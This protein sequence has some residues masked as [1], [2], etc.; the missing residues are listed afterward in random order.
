M[1]DAGLPLTRRFRAAAPHYLAGRAAYAA[2][3]IHLVARL[4]G[5]RGR[6]R[7][8]DLGCGPGALLSPIAHGAVLT[9]IV[10]TNALLAWRAG[11]QS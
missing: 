8:L 7:I 5:L 9:E 1:A 6:D 2:R 10:A 3:L 4:T 11:E